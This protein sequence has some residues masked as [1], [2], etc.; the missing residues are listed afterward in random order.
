MNMTAEPIAEPM[1][2]VF[3]REPTT[4]G[5]RLAAHVW[6]GNIKYREEEKWTGIYRNLPELRK[7][8]GN[9]NLPLSIADG[10]EAKDTPHSVTFEMLSRLGMERD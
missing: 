9:E 6:G 10:T 5:L 3:R 4:D 8:L 2:A 7:A 1:Q